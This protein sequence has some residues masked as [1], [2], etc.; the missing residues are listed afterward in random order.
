MDLEFK[1]ILILLKK[2]IWVLLINIMLFFILGVTISTFIIAPTYKSDVKLIV[3]SNKQQQDRLISISDIEVNSKL[4][5]T[6]SEIVKS[7]NVLENIIKELKLNISYNDLYNNIQ[8]ENINQTGIIKI[9]VKGKEAN[10]R[11]ATKR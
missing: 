9:S 6:Y 11:T 8:I 4:G 2:R 10:T 7:K 1:Q 5:E 3:Y